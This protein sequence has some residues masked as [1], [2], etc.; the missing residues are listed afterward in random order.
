MREK[1]QRI[2]ARR[3]TGEFTGTPGHWSR[4]AIPWRGG[5]LVQ[6]RVRKIQR[7]DQESFV[8]LL[9]GIRP[10]FASLFP[11]KLATFFTFDP[12]VLPNLFFDEVSDPVERIGIQNGRNWNVFFGLQN[13]AHFDSVNHSLSLVPNRD[14]VTEVQ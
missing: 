1:S 3:R 6:I 2:R 9:V 13:F 11:R 4:A 8:L 12:L 14:A 5:L 10:F 7:I